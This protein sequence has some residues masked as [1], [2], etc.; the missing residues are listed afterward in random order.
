MQG[1]LDFAF[2]VGLSLRSADEGRSNRKR[3][4]GSGSN[5][6][7]CH[8]S[9]WR[10]SRHRPRRDPRHQSRESQPRHLKM[11]SGISTLKAIAPSAIA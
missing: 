11:P 10:E 3:S 8:D 2:R 6:R 1:T 9:A 7:I 4:N 5:R